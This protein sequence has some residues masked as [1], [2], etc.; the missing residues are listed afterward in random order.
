MDIDARTLLGASH[1]TETNSSSGNRQTC[2]CLL[3]LQQYAPQAQPTS[4]LRLRAANS[5]A[6]DC[7]LVPHL[8]R[9]A[10]APLASPSFAASW[11]SASASRAS[12]AAAAACTAVQCKRYGGLLLA[13]WRFTSLPYHQ[14]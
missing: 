5:S 10:C 12:A 13:A 2:D 3:G 7:R 14:Q 8:S 4:A 1:G 11:R 9:L 6:F